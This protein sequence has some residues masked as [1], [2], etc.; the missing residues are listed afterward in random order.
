V[1]TPTS[2]GKGRILVTGATG[3]VGSHLIPRLLAQ[4]FEVR[5]LVR[6]GPNTQKLHELGAELV[7][8]DLLRPESLDSAMER[9]KAVVHLAAFFRGTP[10]QSREV[11]LRGTERLAT[12][13][14]RAGVQ[15]FVFVSTGTVY[16]PGLNRPAAESDSPGPTAPSS[17]YAAS[18][19]EAEAKLREINRDGAL[20]L[21]IL[22]FG[23]V[24]GEG[25]RHVW[26]VADRTLDW[27]PARRLHP[28]HH[29]DVAQAVLRVISGGKTSGPVYNIADD[30][31]ITLLEMMRLARVPEPSAERFAL[32]FDPWEELMDTRRAREELGFRPLY[33][34]CYSAVDA[35][36]F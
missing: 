2:T 31:P 20:G 18:K 12:A 26:E 11:N 22:R 6:P 19:V 35:G 3:K 29:A 14:R 5:A 10:E 36:A 4:G 24:Y 7:E 33:P 9:V 23:M 27:N 32:P 16:P 34:S 1:V 28:L 30:A 13:A 21:C 8:T 17:P 25:D 15:R